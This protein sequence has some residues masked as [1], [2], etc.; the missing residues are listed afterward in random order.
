M[1]IEININEES[2]DNIL[3]AVLNEAKDYLKDEKRILKERKKD[4]LQEYEK[5]DLKYNKKLLKA[6]KVVL[7]YYGG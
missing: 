2:L 7:D 5:K 4:G 1:K 6:M 3:I